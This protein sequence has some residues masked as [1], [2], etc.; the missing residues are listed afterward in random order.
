MTLSI[1][2]ILAALGGFA[3]VYVGCVTHP[4]EGG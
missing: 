1:I 2:G 4:K 3:A